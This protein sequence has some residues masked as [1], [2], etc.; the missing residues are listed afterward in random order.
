[1]GLAQQ[2]GQDLVEVLML[3]REYKALSFRFT[4]ANPLDVV[5]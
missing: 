4:D 2:V 5:I 3:I 1:M